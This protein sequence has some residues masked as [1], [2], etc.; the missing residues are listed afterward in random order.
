MR[1][2]SGATESVWMQTTEPPP[3]EPIPADVRT[4]VCV[5]GAGVSGM[6]TAYLLGRAGKAVTVIDNGPIGSGETGRTTAHLTAVLDDRYTS[7]VH[8]HGT[9]NA[10]RAAESHMAAIERIEAIADLE[11]IDCDFER[12]NGYLFL[13]DGDRRDTL[14]KELHALHT[15]GF[16]NARI[17]P[18]APVTAFDTGIAIELARQA[19][20]HPLKY[21]NG[22]AK[23]IVRDG[24]TIACGTKAMS[25]EDGE[26][27]TVKTADGHTILADDVVVATN[28]PV[29]DWMVMHS[30]LAPYRTYVIA[31]RIPTGSVP[32]VLLWD[33]SD[34]YHYVRVFSEP[35][36]QDELL[37]V[38]G[39]DHKTGQSHDT[40]E[41][42]ARLERWAR[43]RFSMAGTIRFRWSGQVLEPVD[44]LAYIGRN[45]G[46]DKHIYIITGSSGNGMTGGT[47]GGMLITDLLLEREN[48][49]VSLYDPGRITM[50]SATEY[51]RENIN[52]VEQ[53]AQWLTPGDVGDVDDIE[54]G[55]GAVIRR[56]I[57]KIAVYKDETGHVTERSAVCTHLYC[58]VDWN[59]TEKTWDC[60]CHGS[61]FDAYGRVVTGPAIADLGPPPTQTAKHTPTRPSEVAP[62]V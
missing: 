60:P 36:T 40:E 48:P 15:V 33:T 9:D 2:E 16:S 50:R 4:N 61:R 11:D 22:L 41:R 19:Q 56:G 57:H 12:V 59:D 24:G 30:K 26:P 43:N 38:G 34:P 47:L 18:H 55:S 46:S 49:W 14:D 51:A 20:F 45:P 32:H 21:L 25:I 29:N 53:Y 37:I 44:G 54:P 23:A 6:T 58:I 10:R 1:P 3:C 8:L 28:S 62:A 17:T 5:I 39:E 42:F 52:V 27:A 7:L 13:G 31:F 35:G